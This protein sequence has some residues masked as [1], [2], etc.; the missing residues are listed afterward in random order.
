ML[1][2]SKNAYDIFMNM[3]RNLTALSIEDY[4]KQFNEGCDAL[5]IAQKMEKDLQEETN[6]TVATISAISYI[7][8]AEAARDFCMEI[9]NVY[10]YCGYMIQ[11]HG[12]CSCEGGG[13]GA[14]EDGAHA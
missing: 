11:H 14:H 10:S 12:G 3:T 9:P 6:I 7:R 1:E 2:N 13:C 8:K 5:E 4:E